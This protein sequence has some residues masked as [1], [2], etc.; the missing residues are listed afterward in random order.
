MHV[1]FIDLKRFEPNFLEKWSEK[2]SFLSSRASFM[3]GE[4][5]ELLEQ[6][7]ANLTEN[8]YSISCAN[9]TDAMQLAL[10]ALNI[11][12]GDNFFF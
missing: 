7:L 3:G 9:G 6:N 2:V 1:P 12:N 11:R 8:K 10:R 5:V 4:E